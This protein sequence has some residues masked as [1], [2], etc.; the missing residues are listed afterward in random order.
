MSI[1]F[2]AEVPSKVPASVYVYRLA[3]PQATAR[4]VARASQR[5]GLTGKAPDFSLSED[6]IT[7]HEGRYQIGV[8][9]QSGALRY[10]HRD[11]YGR[12]T[13]EAFTL[14]PRESTRVALSFLKR[15][16]LIPLKDAAFHK[17]THLR[18][19]TGDVRGGTREE[20]LLDAGVIYRRTVE[21]V[22]VEGPGGFAM[23]NVGPGKEVTG[24]SS[25]WRPTQKRLA[26]VKIMSPDQAV[27]QLREVIAR[28]YGDTT[29]TKATFGY[30]ELGELDRQVYLQP[31]YCFVY[32][33]QNGNIAHKSIEVIA[34]GDRTFAKLLGEKRFPTPPQ[35]KRKVP[36]PRR[37]S[38]IQSLADTL[39]M[40][41]TRPGERRKR[42]VHAG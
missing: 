15:H 9:R 30:F 19:G 35:A 4:A 23:V 11:K 7:Y 6:W 40:S 16:E 37:E 3:P 26:K 31:A 22:P 28:L 14:E 21:G 29:V 20:K 27:A 36:A 8:H 1:K 12:E 33:V 18:S 39:T 41:A 5:F 10:R 13:A 32:V 38:D 25:I 17:V 24:L 42:P 2:A 34:A